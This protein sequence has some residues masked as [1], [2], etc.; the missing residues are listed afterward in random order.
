MTKKEDCD[1]QKARDTV[2]AIEKSLMKRR[3]NEKKQGAFLLPR[4]N[5]QFDSRHSLK[6]SGE[7][8][9]WEDF[10]KIF[11]GLGYYSEQWSPSKLLL[12]GLSLLKP[13]Y[14]DQGRGDEGGVE[15]I[16]CQQFCG[17]MSEIQWKL[18]CHPTDLIPFLKRIGK[19]II[20]AISRGCTAS[21]SL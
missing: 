7:R 16:Y 6:K 2:N 10:G 18:P 4:L 15:K 1:W 9:A 3:K 17:K 14:Y 21:A 19:T 20:L 5:E 12:G 8:F 13:T 11:A